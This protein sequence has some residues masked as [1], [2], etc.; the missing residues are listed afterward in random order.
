MANSKSVCQPGNT[1]PPKLIKQ[2][3][4]LKLLSDVRAHELDFLREA[5]CSHSGVVLSVG[6]SSGS[7]YAG[8]GK[9]SCTEN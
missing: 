2:P 8:R 1:P 3:H 9:S 5:A 6:H 4:P 7:V